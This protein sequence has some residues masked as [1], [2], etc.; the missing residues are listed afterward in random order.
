[1]MRVRELRVE[2]RPHPSGALTD[3]KSILQPSQ[4]AA[5]LRP[6]L[7]NQAQEV[8]LV[9]LLNTKYKILGVHEVSRGG[10]AFCEVDN[11]LIIRAALLA[12]A[13][14]IIVAHNHPSGDANP[15][16]ADC[17]VTQR[18]KQAC[19]IMD[20]ELVD[21]IIIG[22]LNYCSFKDTGRI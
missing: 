20:L 15:S 6:M 14:A 5:I 22:D 8:F 17:A 16:P 9:M 2:Y 13:A 19:E 11:K 7:E 1:M 21:S 4:S 12:N 10:L 3:G 18:I